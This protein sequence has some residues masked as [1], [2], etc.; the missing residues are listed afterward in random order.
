MISPPARN[1]LNSS[2]V[3]VTSLRATEGEPSLEVHPVDAAERSIND[4]DMVRVFNE[5]GSLQLRVRVTDRARRGCVVALSIWWKKLAADG[6]NANEVTSPAL[7]D[8]GRGPTFYDC[9]VQ[10]ERTP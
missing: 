9:L 5:R 8:I 2:F 3:N 1:F 4:G 7:T 10:V 6:C